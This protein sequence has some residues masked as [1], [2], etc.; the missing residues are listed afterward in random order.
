MKTE[1]VTIW[2]D[3][4]LRQA[5]E[6][7]VEKHIGTLPVVDANHRLIGLLTITDLLGLFMPDFV[8]LLDQIDFVHDFGA[9]ENV[10]PQADV[11][12]QPVKTV[13]RKPIAIQRA[14]GLLRA[15]AEIAR[16]DLR[17]LP[18]VDEHGVL[19]GIASQVDIGITF[20]NRWLGKLDNTNQ[21]T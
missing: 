9:L 19:V 17:D 7:M 18:V 3:Q 4:T 8:N 15:F 1:V 21:D 5:V 6:L 2:P 14:G 20:L 13:M 12:D 16:H 11:V 10:R